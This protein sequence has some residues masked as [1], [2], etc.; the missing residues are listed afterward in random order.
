MDVSDVV[1]RVRETAGDVAVLQFSNA[2]L[3]DWINDAIRACV[4]ENSL[5]QA[6]ATSNTVVGQ[7]DYTLPT[8]MFKIHSVYMDSAKIPVL[9]LSEWEDNNYHRDLTGT[10]KACLVYA[11]V[12][13]LYPKP[14]AVLPMVINYTQEATEITY[15]AEPEAWT[16][17]TISIPEAFHSRI[18]TYCLA[19]V[20][21]QD[22]DM[23]KYQSLMQMFHTGVNDLNHLKDQTENL[24]PFPHFVD[25]DAEAWYYNG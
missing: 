6:R 16:P 19:Q 8:D 2:T 23:T 15:V 22:D 20:A 1:R 13:S 10:P 14:D 24:Y 18:V 17:D 3:T 11:G 21:M 25:R 4:E 7:Q 12:L 5:L 9:T